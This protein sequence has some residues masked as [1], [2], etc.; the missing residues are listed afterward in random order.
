MDQTT[1]IK[2]VQKE[3]TELTLLLQ[4][5]DGMAEIPQ[6]IKTLTVSKAEHLLDALRKLEYA[7]QAEIKTEMVAEVEVPI[8]ASTPSVIPAQTSITENP[9]QQANEIIQEV[10][11]EPVISQQKTEP[12]LEKA[13]TTLTEEP[14]QIPPPIIEAE[15]VPVVEPKVQVNAEQ[16]QILGETI[17]AGKKVG[18]I[19]S[20][21]AA[22]SIG[23]LLG[24]SPIKDLK[25]AI[26]LNDRF[27][28][29]KDLFSN[30]SETFLK[31]IDEINSLSS[32]EAALDFISVQFDW[33]DTLE[34]KKDF[35]SLINRRFL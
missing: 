6:P 13:E 19:I 4:G 24:A 8:P 23:S 15:K 7:R 1:I 32:H 12:I 35:L 17:V 29:Q 10:K 11:V 9:I 31:T 30:S 5:F 34:A 25:K 26:N 2:L 33:D 22:N 16:K 27:R 21:D 20:S 28:F 18:D 14:V 3:L